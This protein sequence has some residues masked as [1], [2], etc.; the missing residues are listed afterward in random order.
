[1]LTGNYIEVFVPDCSAEAGEIMQVRIDEI[2]GDEVLGK[3][4]G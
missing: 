1:V 4:N 3:I 2:S